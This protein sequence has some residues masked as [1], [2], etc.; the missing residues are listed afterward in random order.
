MESAGQQS[1]V[2]L[3][4]PEVRAQ[5]SAHSPPGRSATI[6]WTPNDDARVHAQMSGLEFVAERADWALGL[7]CFDQLDTVDSLEHESRFAPTGQRDL[8]DLDFTA[9]DYTVSRPETPPPSRRRRRRRRRSHPAI[10][11]G[12]TALT[13]RP[14]AP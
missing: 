3:G 6:L 5:C 12:E 13:A 10:S 7:P 14:H 2:S 9:S 8:A 4:R 1:E 11:L